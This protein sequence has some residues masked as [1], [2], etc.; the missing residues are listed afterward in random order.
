MFEISSVL[1]IDSNHP[2]ASHHRLG[3]PF[4]L[5]EY[6]ILFVEVA[7]CE[8]FARFHDSHSHSMLSLKQKTFP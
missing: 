2:P 4:L 1:G 6:H 5:P 8:F 3:C 7:K